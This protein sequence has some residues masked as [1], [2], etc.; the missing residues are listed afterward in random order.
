MS[1]EE[2][3]LGRIQFVLCGSH[4]ASDELNPYKVTAPEVRQEI[5]SLINLKPRTLEEIAD[6]LR[7]S[8]DEVAEHLAALERPALIERLGHR[9]K[10]NFAIFTVQDQERMEPLVDELSGSFAKVVQENMGMIYDTYVACGFC[11]HGFTF[12][13]MAYILVGP[14]TFDYGGL[15]ALSKAGLLIV[16]KPMPRGNYVFSGFEGELDLQAKWHWGHSYTFGRFT[17]FGHGEVPK[18]GPR[19]AFPERAYRW[20][21]EGVPE[22]EI[23][24][25]MEE[26]GEIISTLYQGPMDQRTLAGR[27]GIDQERLAAHLSLLQE[28]AYVKAKGEVF[29]SACP[30]VDEAA[31]GHIRAMAEALQEKLID[32][33][34]RPNWS[35]LE[36]VYRGTAPARNGIDLKEAFNPIYHMIFEQA[37]RILMDQG[38]IPRP[39]KRSDEARYAIW[40]QL[41]EYRP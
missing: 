25:R 23:A 20:Y 17:F 36:E 13:D 38:I 7:L 15:K 30:V 14:Y 40:V 6:I 9:Y 2:S 26:I 5:L 21:G 33:I 37:S 12:D 31:L 24:R 3:K 1:E 11:S 16:S 22:M 41:R 28:L 35:W 32:T 29:V 39:R 8:K 27:T 34:I 19:D 18:E 4:E 10:P